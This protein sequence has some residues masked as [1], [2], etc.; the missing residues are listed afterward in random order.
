MVDPFDTNPVTKLWVTI[1]NNDLFI[2]KLNEYL[3]L[4]KIAVEDEQFFFTLAF[5]KDKLHNR[6]G[7]HLDTTICMFPQEF[8]I[9][10]SFPYQEAI[11]AWKDQKVQIAAAF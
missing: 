2:Q 5:M 7:L 9:Q 8:Y 1:N 4:A 3:K 11:T 6:L 10:K